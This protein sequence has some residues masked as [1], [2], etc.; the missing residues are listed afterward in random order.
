MTF[1]TLVKSV[2]TLRNSKFAKGDQTNSH[3]ARISPT[4]ETNGT[5]NSQCPPTY[6]ETSP[7]S[8]QLPVQE[9]NHFDESSF[10]LDIDTPRNNTH[11]F[12]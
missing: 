9:S 8:L 4:P 2:T 11:D 6:Q 12:P 7:G 3:P 1:A 10:Q 5:K